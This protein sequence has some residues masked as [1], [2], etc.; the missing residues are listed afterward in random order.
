MNFIM[1]KAIFTEN[2]PINDA[3][4]LKDTFLCGVF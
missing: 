4:S 2:G 3:K 1:E